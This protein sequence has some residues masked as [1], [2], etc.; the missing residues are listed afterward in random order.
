[1]F[2]YPAAHEDTQGVCK[3]FILQ[4]NSGAESTPVV[5]VQ[6]L[7]LYSSLAWKASLVECKKFR[8]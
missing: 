8:I 2:S 4:S 7:K 5:K 1:M 6:N 3:Y